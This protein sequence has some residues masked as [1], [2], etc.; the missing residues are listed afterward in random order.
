MGQLGAQWKGHQKVFRQAM[1]QK[2]NDFLN[3]DDENECMENSANMMVERSC[4]IIFGIKEA[5]P[6]TDGRSPASMFVSNI[7]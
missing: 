3:I 7:L 2:V 1:G 5:P 4:Y 6:A